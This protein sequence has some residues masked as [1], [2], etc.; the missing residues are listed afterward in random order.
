MIKIA[1]T[2]RELIDCYKVLSPLRPHLGLDKFLA[3]VNR[4]SESTGY[5]LAFLFESEIKAVVGFRIAE[6][7]HTGLYLE[8]EELITIEEQRSM[9]YGSR[10]FDWTIAFAKE[11]ECKQLR[12]VSGVSRERAHQFYLNKG[13]TF[14]A[15][16]FSINV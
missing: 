2:N 4:M 12:L 9:G 15:K 5:Q 3:N 1:E 10:L 16:Y 8:I 14:E 11:N 13:M 6:W 7:L